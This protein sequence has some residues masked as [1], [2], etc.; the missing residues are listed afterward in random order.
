MADLNNPG[1]D[2]LDSVMGK[3]TSTL[4]NVSAKFEALV[5]P[6][7]RF[8]E[9]LAPGEIQILNQA[10]RD[11]NATIGTAFL[12]VIQNLGEQIHKAA[13]L[14]EP[15]TEKLAPVFDNLSN[16]MGN[17]MLPAVQVL[18]HTLQGLAPILDGVSQAFVVFSDGVKL[19]SA[20]M[21]SLKDAIGDFISGLLGGQGNALSTTLEKLKDAVYRV[22]TVMVQAAAVIANTFGA[23]SFTAALIKNLQ[24]LS[25]GKAG[26]VGGAAQNIQIKGL[27]AFTKDLAIAAASAT[28]GDKKKDA[29]DFAAETVAALQK[30]QQDGV[31]IQDF[32][33]FEKITNAITK[34]IRE[35]FK[36]AKDAAVATA[37]QA[38]KGTAEAIGGAAGG[39]LFDL[40]RKRWGG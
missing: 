6:M 28:G 10:F 25:E 33:N 15:A 27:E 40:V 35:G 39:G 18:S 14:L 30:I 24:E 1:M 21:L 26:G 19:A 20:L 13:A 36:Q 11:L 5:T 17:L 9:A 38:A 16:A 37:S 29:T 7:S 2:T 31:K 12:P 3:L 32:V 34:A 8:V 4:T 23:S 22:M